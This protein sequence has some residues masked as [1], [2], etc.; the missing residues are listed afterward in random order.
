MLSEGLDIGRVWFSFRSSD[1]IPTMTKR[2]TVSLLFPS[3]LFLTL[4]LAAF[5]GSGMQS[6]YR[7]RAASDD[8]NFERLIDNAQSGKLQL[9]QG[10]WIEGMRRELAVTKAESQISDDMAGWLRFLG[11][12]GLLSVCLQIAAVF[13]V[14]AKCRKEATKLKP[15]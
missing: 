15:E 3:V 14:R 8:Q 6:R 9:T 7:Q 2:D 4:A 12:C 10:A 1:I 13:S 11:W 5:I